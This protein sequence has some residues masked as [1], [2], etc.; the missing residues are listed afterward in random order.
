MARP[1]VS[2]P[3]RL[4]K[5]VD[6]FCSAYGVSRSTF[7]TWRRQGLGPAEIQ[8]V[9]GGRIIISEE[10]EAQWKAKFTTLASVVA[11]E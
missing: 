7:E 11:A 4:G 5:S 3:K 6:E 9:R 1:V 8:P 10:A 2:K